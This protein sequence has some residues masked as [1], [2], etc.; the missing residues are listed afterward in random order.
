V[1]TPPALRRERD[2]RGSVLGERRGQLGEDRQLF[3]ESAAN[4]GRGT[5]RVDLFVIFL[6]VLFGDFV[7]FAGAVAFLSDDALTLPMTATAPGLGNTV[8]SSPVDHLM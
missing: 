8:D 2:G 3:G 7:A 6:A 5:Y 1:S 4:G